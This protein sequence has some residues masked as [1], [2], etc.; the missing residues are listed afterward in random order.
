VAA[1]VIYQGVESIRDLPFMAE[2]RRRSKRCPSQSNEKVDRTPSSR[3][4][5]VPFGRAWR[6][7]S[8]DV[9]CEGS[10]L[11]AEFG[12]RYAARDPPKT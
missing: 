3:H 11:Q 10:V 8:G 7:S 12:D 6:H 9:P 2:V 4:E 5:E 1:Y